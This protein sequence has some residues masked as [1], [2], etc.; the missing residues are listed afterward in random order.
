[1][2]RRIGTAEQ[3]LPHTI[4]EIPFG[5]K[6]AR[7]CLRLKWCGFLATALRP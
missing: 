5:P 4:E 1:M 6:M 7:K 3:V 2:L